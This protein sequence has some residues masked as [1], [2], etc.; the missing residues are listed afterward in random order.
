VDA[1]SAWDQLEPG[2]RIAFD[3][4]WQAFQNGS[5]PVGAT[6]VGFDGEVLAVG[7][8]RIFEEGGDGLAG[9]LLAHAEV[10]ALGELSPDAR[11]DG[12]TLFTTLE[13]CLFC[14]GAVVL[15]RVGTVRFAGADGYGGA[16]SFPLN[17]NAQ[18]TRYDLA[19]HGPLAGP[20]GRL[21][22]ALTLAY[23]LASH[24]WTRVIEHARQSDPELLEISRKLGR[25]EA[26]A[27][28]GSFEVEGV[29]EQAWPVL[30]T[31]G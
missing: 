29:L 22:A 10:A 21:G 23:L 14:V 31:G 24:R 20:F 26:L 1:A 9:S 18:T 5:F 16:A 25:L 2:W 6:L 7:R 13:P 28:P 3:Q 11:Y 8:N 30:L 12:V 4:A 27:N 17:L 15:S 19:I